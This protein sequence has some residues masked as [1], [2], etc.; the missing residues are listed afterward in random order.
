QC[1]LLGMAPG[2]VVDV[3]V[4]LVVERRD[5][6][7]RERNRRHIYRPD[8]V[9]APAWLRWPLARHLWRRSHDQ[10]AA[11]AVAWHAARARGFN[12]PIW[13]R[14][15]RVAE[16]PHLFGGAQSNAVELSFLKDDFW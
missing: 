14:L 11:G 10:V 15:S 7:G 3:A 2:H 16:C 5:P 8:P 9:G 1:L 4:P 6:A 12:L 13:G